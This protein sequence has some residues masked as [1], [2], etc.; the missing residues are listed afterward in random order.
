M[1]ASVPNHMVPVSLWN[2]MCRIV[3]DTSLIEKNSSVAGSNPI[4]RFCAPVSE[5]Q[6]RPR[7]S[8]VIA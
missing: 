5:N 2:I 3:P 7:S 8:A 4:R 6:S 1:L